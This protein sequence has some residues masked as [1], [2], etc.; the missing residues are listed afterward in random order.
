VAQKILFLTVKLT[1]NLIVYN[2]IREGKTVNNELT[3]ALLL[4]FACVEEVKL[5]HYRPG[6][7][8]MWLRLPEFVDNR[9]IPRNTPTTY[10]C[11][12]LSR[13]HDH[14]AV[15]RIKAIKKFG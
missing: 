7:D 12:R 8:S 4:G 15:G 9:R 6:Q 1:F 14:I 10:F 2:I 5:S 11:Y 3:L 13:T